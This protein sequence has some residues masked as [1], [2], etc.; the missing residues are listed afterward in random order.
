MLVAPTGA[1]ILQDDL[2]V[3]VEKEDE[4]EKTRR[5]KGNMKRRSN[6]ES[7]RNLALGPVNGWSVT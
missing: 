5:Q 1:Q 7:K 2:S 4:K 6:T 3:T